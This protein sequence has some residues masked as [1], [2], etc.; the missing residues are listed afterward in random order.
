MNVF[1]LYE[2][3]EWEDVRKYS[4]MDNIIQ[5]LGL[6]SLFS[7]AA[8]DVI[9]KNGE[10][11]GLA[12]EDEFLTQ[13]MRNVVMV[14]LNSESEIIY[15]HE[16]LEDAVS[17]EEMVYSLYSCVQEMLKKWD[18]LGRRVNGRG[19]AKDS[20][21]KLVS[22]IH[23]LRLFVHSLS[24]IKQLLREEMPTLKSNGF[25]SLY[26][27]LCEE[28]S[29]EKEAALHKVL[30][31]I[32]FY[33]NDV[34]PD[35][36]SNMEARPYIVLG[37]TLTEGLKCSDF[38]VEEVASKVRKFIDPNSVT[39]KL[40]RYM[41]LQQPSIISLKKD[42]NIQGQ[43]VDL[44]F[45]VVQYVVS[46]CMPFVANLEDFFDQMHFQIG[47]YKA[48][49][50]LQKHFKRFR[51]RFCY[52]S[53]C[54]QESMRF[55][56]LKEFVM[57]LEQKI[58]PI[59]NTCDISDAMLM[60]VT[61][62]NQG[63]K[64]TF[65]RSVGIAQIMMQCGLP[66]TADK[67]ES[68][69]FPCFFTHFTR[70]EDSTMNSGRLDE[71]LRRMSQIVDN[72]GERSM[73]LLNESFATTTE[74]EGSIIAYDIIKALTEANVKVLTVTHLLSFAQRMYQEMKENDDANIEF[75]S[76]ERSED[77]KRTFRM[78]VHEPELTSFGID[79]YNSIICEDEGI[80]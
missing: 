27:R 21:A 20:A 61:G 80:Y 54:E 41:S 30:E 18:A 13:V 59:G 64:S 62:A 5:D 9:Y 47:F 10:A 36:H 73:V 33:T 71:E 40:Q 34:Q 65:L 7:I 53:V 32:Y 55:V 68:G 23:I 63:G 4:D 42:P 3:K 17:H 38:V 58:A 75:L 26:E 46:A 31:D 77:G 70:R 57:A 49:I 74:K 25:R 69:I 43:A 50:I 48:G 45:E 66:V 37:C 56:G 52:P 24:K 79:L 2:N 51:L 44:E 39:Q 35:A 16:V 12:M 60:V 22:D 14:P 6:K 76:A 15:R 29:D 78:I 19:I 67:Y 72:I 11:A 8:K 1:L 28:Y